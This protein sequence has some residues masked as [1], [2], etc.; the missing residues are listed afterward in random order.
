MITII[1]NYQRSDIFIRSHSHSRDKQ[2]ALT[3]LNAAR[4]PL[5]FDVI[6]F[7]CEMQ[8][9][10]A[11]CIAN[12]PVFCYKL[13]T[14]FSRFNLESAVW[15]VRSPSLILLSS[16]WLLFELKL[17]QVETRARKNL[18]EKNTFKLSLTPGRCGFSQMEELYV[19]FYNKMRLFQIY[20]NN[21]DY[22][23][24]MNLVSIYQKCECS[25]LKI[26]GML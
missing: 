14:I 1:I 15:V 4:A 6:F 20:M 23:D 2:V 25:H 12:I 11:S 17:R 8:L 16:K 24:I 13:S 22:S 10:N 7:F 5:P 9:N 26:F 19:F 3:I 18:F 21:N